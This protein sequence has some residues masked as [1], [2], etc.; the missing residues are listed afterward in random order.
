LFVSG[1]Q[2]PF[3]GHIRPPIS[4]L[5]D[6]AFIDTVDQRYGGIPPEV[7]ADRDLLMLLLPAL[8]ADLVALEGF[9]PLVGAPVET[10]IVAMRGDSDPL[11]TE[12]QLLPWAKAT[13]G[14]FRVRQFPGGHFYFDQAPGPLQRE[15]S[16]SLLEPVEAEKPERHP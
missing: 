7:L 14:P 15:L 12:D 1:R 3:I 16:M 9:E 6:D 2:A 10:P 4:H 5:D 13:N 8:R 11:V